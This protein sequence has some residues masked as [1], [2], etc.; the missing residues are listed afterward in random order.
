MAFLIDDETR[1]L[2]FLR[3]RLLDELANLE[4]EPELVQDAAPALSSELAQRERELRDAVVRA[5]GL[6]EALSINESELSA[7]DRRIQSTREDRQRLLDIRLLRSLG[8]EAAAHAL[9][10]EDCPTCHQSL[11]AVEAGEADALVLSIDDNVTLLEQRLVTLQSMRESAAKNAQTLL[12]ALASTQSAAGEHRLRIR[13]IKTSLVQPNSSA[14]VAAIER[15]LT[16]SRRLQELDALDGQLEEGSIEL[17]RL[18]NR[19]D[20]LR[21]Q[22]ADLSAEFGSDDL[23]KIGAVQRSMRS[24]LS[25]FGFGSLP[26]DEVTVSQQTLQPAHEGFDLSFDISASDTIRTK[27]AYF[28][29]LAELS[30]TEDTHHLGLL[31]LDEPGQQEIEQPSFRSLLHRA[32]SLA[33]AG[34]QV[35]I[36]T[37][38]TEEF[39]RGS[40]GEDLAALEVVSGKLLTLLNTDPG[41]AG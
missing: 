21:A 6:E 36:A 11:D 24:Q 22:L 37:S 10:Q 14:S 25:E 15:R 33:S 38:E 8:S 30:P 28:M 17:E 20:A 26:V 12:L 13:A 31:I 32:R 40:L 39:V 18:A 29:A 23:R 1:D 4:S 9:G 41:H 19:S 3:S 35:V 16:L 7:L 2:A 27:W 34:G 5:S